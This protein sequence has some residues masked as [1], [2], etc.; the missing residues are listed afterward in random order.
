MHVIAYMTLGVD[1]SKLFYEMIK[2]SITEDIV[3]KKM[4]FLY[5]VNYPHQVEQ[6]SFLAINTFLRDI[7]D[8]NPKV[9]GLALR[10]FCNIKF[11][12]IYEYFANALYDSLKYVHP[13]VIK[14][15]ATAMLKVFHLNPK[16]ITDKD[17]DLLYEMIGDKDPLVAF[18]CY[19]CLI[20]LR[21]NLEKR[22][23]HSAK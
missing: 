11:K 7:K 13:F 20:C 17:I 16:L 14:T 19:G 5:I 8:P 4:I 6:G 1:V 10:M 9:R 23:R 21:K 18:G 15:P 3:M 22:R 2:V 12:G